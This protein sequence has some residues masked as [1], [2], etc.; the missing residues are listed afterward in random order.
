[1]RRAFCLFAAL[2]KERSPAMVAT[3][4]TLISNFK[5]WKFKSPPSYAE[6]PINDNPEY[7]VPVAVNNAVFS[8]VCTRQD[9]VFDKDISRYGYYDV[10]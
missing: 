5:D 8:K 6:L 7:N 10:P 4:D 9:I 3:S 1:M 2:L